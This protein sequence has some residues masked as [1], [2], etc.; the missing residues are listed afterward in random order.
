M[1]KKN[2]AQFIYNP[3]YNEGAMMLDELRSSTLRSAEA[4]SA[5]YQQGLVNAVDDDYNEF[6]TVYP[7][8]AIPQRDEEGNIAVPDNL[9]DRS[10]LSSAF[11]NI[12]DLLFGDGSFSERLK[13]ANPADAWRMFHEKRL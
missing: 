3:R 5:P 1:S 10:W 9:E 11:S 6:G 12:S 2:K 13:N 7:E 4:V 8:W